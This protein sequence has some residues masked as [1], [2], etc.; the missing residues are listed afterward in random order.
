MNEETLKEIADKALIVK[1][2]KV[3]QSQTSSDNIETKDAIQESVSVKKKSES[4]DK[5]ENVEFESGKHSESGEFGISE[6]E[7]GKQEKEFEKVDQTM[8]KL[9]KTVHGL[10]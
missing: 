2:Q 9:F 8:R 10:S 7:N 4:D 5:S 3:E 6:S 1:L